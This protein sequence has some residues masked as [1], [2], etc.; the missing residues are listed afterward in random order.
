MDVHSVHTESPRRALFVARG[1]FTSMGL[2]RMCPSWGERGGAQ[3]LDGERDLHIINGSVLEGTSTI[4]ANF[5][6]VGCWPEVNSLEDVKPRR[7]EPLFGGQ[8]AGD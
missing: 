1:S 5:L 6:M 7:G 4:P 3:E 2:N 8:A